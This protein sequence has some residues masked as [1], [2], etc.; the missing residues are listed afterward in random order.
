MITRQE[1]AQGIRFA[2]RR[3]AAALD[4]VQDLDHPLAH[5]WT[6][7]DAFRHLASVAGALPSFYPAIGT[8][9][10]GALTAAQAAAGNQQSIHALAA[11]S[12]ADLRQT[13]LDGHEASAAFVETVDDASLNEVITLG[14][15][16]MP[17]AEV[18]AQIWIHHT[19]A[20]AYEATYRWPV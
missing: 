5:A 18:V 3:A 14:G 1:L 16:R 8:A 4:H 19:I 17:R 13:I 7:A 6:T 11:A 12:R 2:G 15:Y 9:E 10:L 20:H